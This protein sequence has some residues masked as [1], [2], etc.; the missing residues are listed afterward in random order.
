[1]IN[2]FKTLDGTE[3]QVVTQCHGHDKPIYTNTTY[4][5]HFDL[6]KL[7]DEMVKLFKLCLLLDGSSI[8]HHISWTLMH[9]TGRYNNECIYG[10]YNNIVILN[11][12]EATLVMKIVWCNSKQYK[13]VP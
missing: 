8:L 1:M 13:A 7:P 3:F 9:F 11:E 12:S 5:F 2:L 4:S 10:V 6:P